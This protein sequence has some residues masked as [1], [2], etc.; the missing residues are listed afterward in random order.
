MKGKN[1]APVDGA[2]FL[3]FMGRSE[4]V[5]GVGLITYSK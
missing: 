3:P 4:G 1:A 5:G 2:A